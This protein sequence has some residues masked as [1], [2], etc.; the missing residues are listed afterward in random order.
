[1]GI[2]L[3]LLPQYSKNDEFSLDVL[4]CHRDS[5]MFSIIKEVEKN[6]GSQIVN[7]IST[8]VAINK[9]GKM[10]YGKTKQTL[11]GK[12]IYSVRA[13]ALKKALAEYKT[14]NWRNKAVISFLNEMP[15]DLEVWL[16]WN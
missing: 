12:N 4:E 6:N 1:M 11:N 16:F 9:K 2:N 8:Y 15:N 13:C 5:D 3:T 7:V 14:K 10:R